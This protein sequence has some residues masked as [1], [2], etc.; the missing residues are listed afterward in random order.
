M[1]VISQKCSIIPSTVNPFCAAWSHHSGGAD[2]W[3]SNE[4]PEASHGLAW[5]VD[6]GSHPWTIQVGHIKIWLGQGKPSEAIRDYS[7]PAVPTK[8]VWLNSVRTSKRSDFILVQVTLRTIIICV[9]LSR[10]ARLGKTV[11]GF[12]MRLQYGSCVFRRGRLSNLP[13]FWT[14]ETTWYTSPKLPWNPMEPP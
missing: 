8:W 12:P 3:P 2:W 9:K 13:M 7:K 14:R 11:G 10:E 4:A 5:G 1:D 6:D